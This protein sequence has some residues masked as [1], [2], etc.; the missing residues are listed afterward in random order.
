M[1]VN[2]DILAQS[3][4]NRQVSPVWA[5]LLYKGVG[6]RDKLEKASKLVKNDP[7]I[8]LKGLLG[9]SLLDKHINPFFNKLTPDSVKV[10]VLKQNL[11]L[12]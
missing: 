2:K 4:F 5:T 1:S 8:L 9:K 10:D 7:S 3:S 11:K 6:E 12:V